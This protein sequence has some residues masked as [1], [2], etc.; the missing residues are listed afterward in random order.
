ML[1]NGD[2]ADLLL[3]F[4]SENSYGYVAG[5]RYDYKDGETETIAK[6]CEALKDGDT[7]DFICDYYTYDGEYQD[8]YRMGDRMTVDG[9]LTISNIYI[10][11]QAANATYRFTD[12]YNQS[13]WTPVMP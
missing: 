2:R 1:L 12:I 4:D 9:E 8:S 10:D 7:L 13:Y 5:V 3:V 11:K 6:N